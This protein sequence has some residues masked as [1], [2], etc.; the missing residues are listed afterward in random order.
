MVRSR[1]YWSLS[2]LVTGLVCTVLLFVLEPPE[3]IY[4]LL[5][6]P[7]AFAASLA[8]LVAAWTGR[9]P[10]RTD[11]TDELERVHKLVAESARQWREQQR[12]QHDRS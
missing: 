12:D 4:V 11:E 8:L 1:L 3:A 5:G 2:F 6:A 9:P 7:V 10:E